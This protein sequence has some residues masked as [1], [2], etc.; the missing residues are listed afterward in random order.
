MGW[1]SVT[2]SLCP[3][4]EKSIL[5]YLDGTQERSVARHDRVDRR[6][7]AKSRGGLAGAGE[8]R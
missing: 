7:D 5:P 4:P 3:L 6:L 1:V 2:P 8:L